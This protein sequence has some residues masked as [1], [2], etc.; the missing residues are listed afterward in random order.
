MGDPRVERP[1][2]RRPRPAVTDPKA[3]VVIFRS[4][5]RSTLGNGRSP[6]MIRKQS[7]TTA[8]VH[9]AQLPT[10][11]ISKVNGCTSRSRTDAPGP[12]RSVI[13]EKCCPRSRHRRPRLSIA[14]SHG[15]P[16]C[17]VAVQR[18]E[19]FAIRPRSDTATVQAG[20][21]CDRAVERRGRRCR[22]SWP[23]FV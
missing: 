9:G 7:R 2:S 16:A 11:T 18:E 21:P 6:S 8:A 14:R 4:S 23:A 17:T 10:R 5:D 13:S 3:S 22:L 19:S 15:L 1:E 12:Q 20:R